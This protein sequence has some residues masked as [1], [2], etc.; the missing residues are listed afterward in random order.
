MVWDGGWRL[1]RGKIGQLEAEELMRMR[2]SWGFL[3]LFVLSYPNLVAELAVYILV[4]GMPMRA[5]RVES[6]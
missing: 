4:G 1:R 2:P 6:E 3:N 5:Y